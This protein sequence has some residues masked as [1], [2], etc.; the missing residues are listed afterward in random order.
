M[1]DPLAQAL[2][3]NRQ[4]GGNDEEFFETAAEAATSGGV[5][6][7]GPDGVLIAFDEGDTY[8]LWC[9]VGNPAKFFSLAPER[10]RFI[11]FARQ[12]RGREARKVVPW[13]RMQ[14]LLL[15]HARKQ[16]AATNSPDAGGSGAALDCAAAHG[17][18]R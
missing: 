11:A 5:C 18:G 17:D 16:K 8:F 15:T 3:L 6:Y 4:A 2:A 14:N 10:K 9:A 7:I 12:H 1:H 13:D